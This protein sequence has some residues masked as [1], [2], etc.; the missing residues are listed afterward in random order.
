[1][2]SV[3]VANDVK[4]DESGEADSCNLVNGSVVR[5]ATGVASR[6][7]PPSQQSKDGDVYR[8]ESSGQAF[9]RIVHVL[10][11]RGSDGSHY[12]AVRVDR[13]ETQEVEHDEEEQRQRR[14]W[15]L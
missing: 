5:V 1:M 12:G 6:S 15:K 10:L 3:L 7:C 13:T 9:V 14:K 11:L 2:S 4:A 8:E